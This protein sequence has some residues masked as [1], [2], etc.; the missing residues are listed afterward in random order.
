MSKTFTQKLKDKLPLIISVTVIAVL[1]GLYFAFPEFHNWV[2]TAFKTL[3]SDDRNRIKAY[4]DQFGAWGPAFLVLAMVAQMFLIVI[5]VVAL[6][7]VAVLAYGPFWGSVIALTGILTAST[8]GYWVGRALGP[9]TIERLVGKKTTKK[10]ETNVER[11][12]FW[13]IIVVRLSPFLSDDAIGFV[14]GLLKMNYWRFMLATFVGVLPLTVLIAWLSTEIDRLTTGLIW[15]S[16]I[17]L[18]AFLVF[19]WIDKRKKKTQKA[20]SG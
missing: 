10:M 4:V 12:G 9:H 18:A 17:S 16:V 5:N 13:G 20:V 6:M 1:V 15:I 11:Y 3:T 14:A 2:K 8:V 19:V 7:V